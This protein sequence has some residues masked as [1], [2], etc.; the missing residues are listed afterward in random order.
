M[1]QP[2]KVISTL[3]QDAHSRDVDSASSLLISE[4]FLSLQG[5]GKLTGVPSW[6]CRVS[7]CNLRCAWC[8][9]PYASWE[10][11]GSKRTVESLIDEARATGVNHAVLTGGE[12]MLFAGM[13]AL[14]AGLKQAGFHITIETAGTIDPLHAGSTPLASPW[15]IDLLSL[16]PKLANSA[17]LAGDPRDPQGLWRQRHEA[18]RLHVPTLQALI[19]AYPH[20]QLK[21]VVSEPAQLREIES[22]LA[23]LTG[24]SPRDVL[25]MPEG[26]AQQP[27]GATQWLVEA[28]IAR[29]WTYCTRLHITLFGNKR[30]T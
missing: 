8:D 1:Q 15:P 23:T 24:W 18:R 20:R 13:L 14:A 16:S 5:E 30:G 26:I 12:P 7:G 2:L 27:P 4:T 9:T 21:F 25:L 10:P 6:F 11:S 28:C 3:T 19:D 22:L 29:N 17:P